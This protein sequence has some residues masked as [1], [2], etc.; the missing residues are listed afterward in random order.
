MLR[1]FLNRIALVQSPDGFNEYVFFS[2][3]I[4]ISRCA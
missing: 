2:V 4:I 1:E 3:E